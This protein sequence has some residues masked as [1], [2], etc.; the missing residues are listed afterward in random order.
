MILLVIERGIKYKIDGI[1]LEILWCGG[2]M[3]YKLVF[4]SKLIMFKI[5]S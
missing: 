2:R 3:K 1:Y 5:N 4:L